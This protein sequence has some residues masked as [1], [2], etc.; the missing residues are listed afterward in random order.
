MADRN[1]QPPTEHRRDSSISSPRSSTD[2][3]SPPP[4]NTLL[5]PGSVSSPQP[6]QSFSDSLR[7]V[8]AS[9]RARRQPSLTQSAI[10]SLI[11]N[12]PTRNAADPAF[13][14]RDW[15]Q[16]TIGELVSPSDLRFVEVDTGIED[17]TNLL[18]DSGAPVLLVR[19]TPEDTA[20]IGTFDYADLNAYLL[21][22]VGLT[23]PDAEHIASM[24]E[25]ARKAREGTK[26]PLK[27][28]K[29]LGL[30]VPLTTLPPSANLM[31]AV[32][33]FGGGVHRII[34]T[35]ENSKEVVG[36]FSQWRLVKFL[37]ENGRSF[38]V[39]DQLYPRY[40]ADLRIGSQ[41]VISIKY[42][43]AMYPLSCYS[44]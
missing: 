3:R 27:D 33:T 24:R 37:W 2:S 15:T 16:I 1:S 31:R 13:S 26:I 25:I 4:R 39:I 29:D 17:A 12:P 36:I 30:N 38:P 6:R 5:R 28:V 44:D 8:P 20:A 32:E 42:V 21:L 10:Q 11:D 18:I 40:L 41:A 14:G 35:K 7:A 19:E 9:P 23:Q 22:V 34:V 43:S